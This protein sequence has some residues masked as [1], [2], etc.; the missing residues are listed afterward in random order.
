M[1]NPLPEAR[2]D[3]EAPDTKERL[4]DAAERLFAVRG[5]V[6]TSMRAVTQ[7]AGAAVSAANYHFGSKEAL[8]AAVMR[9]RV[10]PIN[11]RRIEVLG[12]LEDEAAAG[13]VLCLEDVLDAFFRPSFE[14]FARAREE[15]RGSFPRQVAARLYADPPETV[16]KLKVEVFSEVNER[17][18]S[19]F[20]RAL[21]GAPASRVR[22]VQHLAIASMMHVLAGQLDEELAAM[23]EGEA[24]GSEAPYEPLLSALIT[25]AAAGARAF[26]DPTNG[27]RGGDR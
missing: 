1:S 8:L 13:G 17:F 6:G 15:G 9:R 19:A 16:E 22:L 26:S 4:L 20:A 18:R 12:R 23:L 11:A 7:A 5:F 27:G 10:E 2:L 21:P 14:Q 3:A 25:Q 24:T